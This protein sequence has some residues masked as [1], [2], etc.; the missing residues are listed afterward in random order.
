VKEASTSDRLKQI[1]A[2]RNMK[3]VDILNACQPY[4]KKYGIMLG[5]SALSQYISGR[6]LPG[7]HKLSILGM[8]LNVNEA[9]LMG[10]DVSSER[11]N[12]DS[13]KP[14]FPNAELFAQIEKKYG[15]QMLILIQSFSKLDE[16]DRAKVIERIQVLLE[17]DKYQQD[18]LC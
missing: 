2:E 7:Q 8:A 9:W 4:C 12:P 17:D 1:M 14:T 15:E 13:L 10:Y 3:Q 16:V 18:S 6:V 11:S 5:K